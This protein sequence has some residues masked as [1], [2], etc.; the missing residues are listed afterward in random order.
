MNIRKLKKE[1][2]NKLERIWIK[3]LQEWIKLKTDY[4]LIRKHYINYCKKQIL[5][6]GNHIDIRI[7]NVVQ[8]KL[9]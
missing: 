7:R 9:I 5:C 2:P 4:P 6:V 1:H 8:Q 3:H